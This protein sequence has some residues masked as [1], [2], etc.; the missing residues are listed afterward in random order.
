VRRDVG[1]AKLKGLG[2]AGISVAGRIPLEVAI[3]M[4]DRVEP[5]YSVTARLFH[6]VVAALVLLTLPIG[7]VMANVD[8]GPAQDALYEPNAYRSSDHDPV[9]VGLD[10]AT[11]YDDLR[12]LVRAAVDHAGI[13]NSLI[14]KL[15]AAERAEARGDLDAKA[16]ALEAFADELRAQAGKA[17]SEAD[18]AKLIEI[19]STL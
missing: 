14:V 1:L 12:R 8:V 11:S 5:G 9:L 7:I 15:N 2:Y 4:S 16:D 10:L 6:W 18:A 17:I 13:E 3:A 19:A